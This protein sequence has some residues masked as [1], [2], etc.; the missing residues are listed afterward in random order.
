[1]IELN[2]VCLW[3]IP[4]VGD[5]TGLETNEEENKG[6]ETGEKPA[7]AAFVKEVESY[8]QAGLAVVTL[9]LTGL[10]G[11]SPDIHL[12]LQLNKADSLLT[13]F[14]TSEAIPSER[15]IPSYIQSSNLVN[16][17]FGPNP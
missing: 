8:Q 13:N 10:P 4:V 15:C 11:K 2:N 3:K 12:G 5:E 16:T 7:A 14:F 1:M 17:T 9:D 6:L